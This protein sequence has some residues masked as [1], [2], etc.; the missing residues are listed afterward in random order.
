M[1]RFAAFLL[2]LFP[3]VANAQIIIA[4][5]VTQKQLEDARKQIEAGQKVVSLATDN[6]ARMN[7][8]EF[9]IVE[10]KD[11][12]DGELLW[13]WTNWAKQT[14]TFD[15]TDMIVRHDVPAGVEVNIHMKRAGEA[16]VKTHRFPPQPKP[17]SW[18]EAAADGSATLSVL[19]NGDKGKSPITVSN[20]KLV[21]G[22]EP[23]PPPI[24]IPP[25]PVDPVTP[26]VATGLRVFF[27]TDPAAK[28]TQEQSNIM[29]SPKIIAWLNAKCA[30]D[31]KGKPSWRMWPK[32]VTIDTSESKIMVDAWNAAKPKFG[33]FPLAVLIS[34][35]NGK[36]VDLP[37]TEA[38]TLKLLETWGGK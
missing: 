14:V 3:V 11:K 32:N 38:E 34:D 15:T 29:N 36:A 23:E 33:T 27:V 28:I 18:I 1:L 37:A 16:K 8:G 21:I 17:W 24:V 4:D 10:R 2:L 26:T 31:E 19:A 6:T 20:I 25:K 30:K 35:Q 12:I 7:V 9:D 22:T 5:G 13:Q